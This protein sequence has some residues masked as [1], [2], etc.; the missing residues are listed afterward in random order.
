M[1]YTIKLSK[2]DTAGLRQTV[3]EAHRC[4]RDFEEHT[5]DETVRSNLQDYFSRL[6]SQVEH[7]A[8]RI[9]EEAFDA[10]RKAPPLS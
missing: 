5:G 6:L 2:E 1:T 8:Q 4:G 3:A 9:A 7:Q 10:G